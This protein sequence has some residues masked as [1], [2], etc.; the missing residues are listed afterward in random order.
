MTGSSVGIKDVAREAGVSITTVSHALNGKGRIPENTRRR[1]RGIADRLGYE[2]NAI[3]RSL[4]GGRTGVIAIA[5]S[6]VDAVPTALTDVDYFSQAIGEATKRALEHDVALVIGPPTPKSELWSRIPLDG[7]VIFDPVVADPVL[8]SLRR[9]GLPLVIVG[10]DPDGAGGDYCVDNDQ[11]AGTRVVLDH[12]AERGA[13]RV[14]LLGGALD[15]SFTRDCVAGYLAWCEDHRM[16]PL[17]ELV[18][19]FDAA[20]HEVLA[21]WFAMSDRPDAVYANFD[22]LGSA[23]L[24]AACDHGLDVPR[25]VLVAVCADR[26]S[27]EGVAVEPTTLNLNPGPTA[28]EAVELLIDVIQGRRPDDPTRIIPTRL[29]PRA[30]TAR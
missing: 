15:D 25:D 2:P 26:E 21:R 27:F 11:V 19:P 10:R 28:T 8:A 29:V 22:A 4:A 24:R 30:S 17:C 6:L 18:P 20:A 1:V 9:R 23:T 3:A 7:V 5:F 13:R 12:L 16:R 14:A